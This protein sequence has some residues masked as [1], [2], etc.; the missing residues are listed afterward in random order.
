MRKFQKNEFLGFNP[1]ELRLLK[2]SLGHRQHLPTRVGAVFFFTP[3]PNEM[4]HC[5]PWSFF[6]PVILGRQTDDLRTSVR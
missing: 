5:H 3:P 6:F 4:S 2:F 1:S